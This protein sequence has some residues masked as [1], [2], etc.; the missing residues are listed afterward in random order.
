MR[1][2]EW[3]KRQQ[4]RVKCLWEEDLSCISTT[5]D[6]YGADRLHH[7][8]MVS[9]MSEDAMIEGRFHQGDY[10]YYT[11]YQ[12]PMRLAY[13]VVWPLPLWVCHVIGHQI[14]MGLAGL[15]ERH[16]LRNTA[17]VMMQPRIPRDLRLC[18]PR[19]WKPPPDKL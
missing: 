14:Y 6:R 18:L 4:A 13:R 15:Y 16:W 8:P 17:P 19:N 7:G 1:L 10:G 12:D 11:V 9:S 2:L 5:T 3:A